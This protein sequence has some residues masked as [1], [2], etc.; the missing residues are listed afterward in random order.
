VKRLDGL[1][2]LQGSDATIE[3]SD[4]QAQQRA[5]DWQA[6]RPEQ[7]TAKQDAVQNAPS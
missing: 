2:K 5:A 6:L 1:D 3:A 7:Q 4:Q